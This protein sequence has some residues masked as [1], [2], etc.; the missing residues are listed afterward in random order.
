MSQSHIC[1]NFFKCEK[2]FLNIRTV[3]VELI[4]GKHPLFSISVAQIFFSV[5]LKLKD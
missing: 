3:K 2:S 1:N 4:I 5:N